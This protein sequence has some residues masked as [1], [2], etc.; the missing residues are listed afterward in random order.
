MTLVIKAGETQTEWRIFLG[1]LLRRWPTHQK[2][3]RFQRQTCVLGIN[4]ML[5]WWFQVQPPPLCSKCPRAGESWSFDSPPHTRRCWCVAYRNNKLRFIEA[6]ESSCAC[7]GW[8]TRPGRLLNCSI[9][10][11]ILSYCSLLHLAISSSCKIHSL[12]DCCIEL[13][14]VV[15]SNCGQ[16]NRQS[17]RMVCFTLAGGA[18]PWIWLRA[19]ISLPSRWRWSRFG[20]WLWSA[21]LLC[22]KLFHPSYDSNFQ[23]VFFFSCVKVSVSDSGT[24]MK[25][26]PAWRAIF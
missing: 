13:S 14:T 9:I 25:E 22:C 16:W 12:E 24:M 26:G 20:R 19:P 23:N 3:T 5:V 18:N 11:L 10:F 6:S 21:V 1:K 8:S 15:S 2:W 7:M 17:S 4:H